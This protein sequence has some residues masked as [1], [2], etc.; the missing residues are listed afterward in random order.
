MLYFTHYSCVSVSVKADDEVRCHNGAVRQSICV[1][2]VVPDNTVLSGIVKRHS[3]ASLMAG[4]DF[5]LEVEMS[6][7]VMSCQTT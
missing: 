7:H 6:C 5:K 1:Q 3:V 2:N 4:A